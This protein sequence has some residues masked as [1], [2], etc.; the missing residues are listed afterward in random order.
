MATG[1]YRLI[2]PYETPS[3]PYGIV[4]DRDG[5]PWVALFNTNKVMRV[6]PETFEFT[7]FEKATPQSRSRRI[8]VTSDGSVWYVDEPRGRLGR[9]DPATGRVR[10]YQ[11]PG[12]EA[13]RPYALTKDDRENLWVSQTGPEKKLV[14]F[15][16][17]TEEFF[18]VNEVSHNIRHKMFHAPTGAMWFG[19][20]ANK[21]GR[22]LTHVAAR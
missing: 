15:D 6:D 12:G 8:E 16:P 10:E 18:S 2:T 5:F 4:I 22:L 11:M 7:L 14:G 20:D 1:E 19:T 3:R 13:S 21:V 17:R 9:I